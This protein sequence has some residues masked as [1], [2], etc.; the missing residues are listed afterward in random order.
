MSARC[1]ERRHLA[2]EACAMMRRTR[3]K[4]GFDP[5]AL[6]CGLVFVAA[7]LIVLAGGSLVH[8]G[9]TLVPAA[10]VGLG[11]ALFVQTSS[12]AR[13]HRRAVDDEDEDGND[14][15]WS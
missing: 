15:D 14:D 11:I 9:R 7:G 12:S 2:V 10:L 5:V 4:R 13:Q 3:P 6:V 1:G 8:D